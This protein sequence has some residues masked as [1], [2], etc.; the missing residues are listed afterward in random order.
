MSAAGTYSVAEM[1]TSG[2]VISSSNQGPSAGALT[3]STNGN[4]LTINAGALT[5]SV[6]A[7]TETITL[8]P[9]YDRVDNRDQPDERQLCLH[10]RFRQ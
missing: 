8:S 1:F 9:H 6:T 5:L 7:G 4:G 3:L 10:G 2:A